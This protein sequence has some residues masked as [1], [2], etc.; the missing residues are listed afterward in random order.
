MPYSVASGDSLGCG[1]PPPKQKSDVRRGSRFASG[2]GKPVRVPRWKGTVLR[3]PAIPDEPDLPLETGL[4]GLKVLVVD[5]DPDALVL[6]TALLRLCGAAVRPV[7]SAS[8][9][10]DAL[11]VWMPDVLLIDLMMPREDGYALLAEVRQRPGRAGRLG[12]VAIT[13]HPG[14]ELRDRVMAAGFPTGLGRMVHQLPKGEASA[15]RETCS[16]CYV[17]AQRSGCW[18]S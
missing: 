9:T 18:H 12:A 2:S 7:R 4:I 5:D 17:S 3:G 8:E 11:Q 1:I 16:R 13:G 10:L 14:D 6:L 15:R